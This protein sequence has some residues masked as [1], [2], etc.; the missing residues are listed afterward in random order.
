MLSIKMTSKF[1]DLFVKKGGKIVVHH[2]FLEK[3]LT[4]EAICNVLHALFGKGYSL[5]DKEMKQ[6]QSAFVTTDQMITYPE[7]RGPKSSPK[8]D[9]GVDVDM[10]Q[11][12]KNMLDAETATGS[13]ITETVQSQM[14]NFCKGFRE[15]VTPVGNKFWNWWLV[16][17]A[18]EEAYLSMS[19]EKKVANKETTYGELDVECDRHVTLYKD[20]NPCAPDGAVKTFRETVMA[21][22]IEKQKKQ[23]IFDGEIDE[24][25]APA[26]TYVVK[27]VRYEDIE[28]TPVYEWQR[29]LEL[30]MDPYGKKPHPRQAAEMKT[31][32]QV[33]MVEMTTPDDKVVEGMGGGWHSAGVIKAFGDG[34]QKYG[35]ESFIVPEE[36]THLHKFAPVVVLTAKGPQDAI[37][38]ASENERK[39]NQ[40]NIFHETI[41]TCLPQVI[42]VLQSKNSIKT[43]LYPKTDQDN[44][45]GRM[46]FKNPDEATYN[47][48]C[49]AF[50]S[51]AHNVQAQGLDTTSKNWTM[52][53]R[54]T[55]LTWLSIKHGKNPPE[56]M[57][58]A[59]G[60][61]AAAQRTIIATVWFHAIWAMPATDDG[62][63]LRE[64][65]WPSM[66]SAPHVKW[67][68]ESMV[69]KAVD[70]MDL[71]D[72]ETLNATY[73]AFCALF[74]KVFNNV[75]FLVMHKETDNVVDIAMRI[76]MTT[77]YNLGYDDL[78]MLSIYCKAKHVE[79]KDDVDEDDLQSFL[80]YTQAVKAKPSYV[81]LTTIIDRFVKV[82]HDHTLRDTPLTKAGNNNLLN[83]MRFLEYFLSHPDNIEMDKKDS[84]TRTAYQLYLDFTLAPGAKRKRFDVA[85]VRDDLVEVIKQAEI[86]DMFDFC[87]AFYKWWRQSP[88]P[89]SILKTV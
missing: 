87:S 27:Q 54:F 39:K 43:M 34:V 70:A 83:F 73:D 81:S 89:A 51:I 77:L 64:K 15:R 28:P 78:G 62:P 75:K 3:G 22:L 48:C 71:V 57:F 49:R 56:R 45:L 30:T 17:R 84:V 23:A 20:A 80:L 40:H 8:G 13:K 42:Q 46:D 26:V 24:P 74:D 10:V 88:K 58:L 16:Y 14:F 66:Q 50:G 4:P 61:F 65:L 1:A 68:D 2:D 79:D 29:H 44:E 33:Q 53:K 25:S 7:D 63:A 38:H 18:F 19:K 55:Y 5:T 82:Q 6:F 60:H 9:P 37:E 76:A 67:T 72:T 12:I 35:H 32:T 11:Q 21:T 52:E 59:L 36:S 31:P 86:I 41:N 69:M 47:V 85:T